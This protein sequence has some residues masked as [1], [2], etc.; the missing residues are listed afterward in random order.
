MRRSGTSPICEGSSASKSASTCVNWSDEIFGDADVE[1]DPTG[2]DEANAGDA[3]V[4]AIVGLET[5]ATDGLAT[6]AAD[7]LGGAEASDDTAGPTEQAATRS[8]ADASP[9]RRSI[10]S[11][12]IT[13]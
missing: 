3:V 9:K 13:R 8:A 10:P 2:E 11:D 4:V 7:G 1:A 5:M 12:P 6:T